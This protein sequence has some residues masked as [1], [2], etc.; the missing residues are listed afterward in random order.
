MNSR[1]PLAAASDVRAEDFAQSDVSG[2]SCDD[3]G[4]DTPDIHSQSQ[5][6][7]RILQLIKVT[8]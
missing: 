2:D 7:L 6:T 5:P 4:A 8:A 1:L 3:A